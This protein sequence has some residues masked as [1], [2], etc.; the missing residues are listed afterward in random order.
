MSS[1][2]APT[3]PTPNE[4]ST[5]RRAGTLLGVTALAALVVLVD[6]RLDA[7]EAMKTA[8]EAKRMRV[9]SVDAVGGEGDPTSSPSTPTA[10]QTPSQ[11]RAT[12]TTTTT[13]TRRI[14]DDSIPPPNPHLAPV[15]RTLDALKMRR[16]APL[17]PQR[18]DASY[19]GDAYVAPFNATS[20][21]K[22]TTR[23]VNVG[24]WPV[25]EYTAVC[26]VRHVPTNSM[27]VS[28]EAGI[29]VAASPEAEQTLRTT[30]ALRTCA[31]DST[32]SQAAARFRLVAPRPDEDVLWL[33]GTTLVVDTYIASTHLD[34]VGSKV[35]QARQL[36]DF[37]SSNARTLTTT[38]TTTTKLLPDRLLFL[39]QSR[40]PSSKRP[41]SNPVVRL[42][43][44][45][46]TPEFMSPNTTFYRSDMDALPR[47]GGNVAPVVCLE[48]ALE[49]RNVFERKFATSRDVANWKKHAATHAKEVMDVSL[50]L[51]KC[52][53]R[54]ND[55][56]VLYRTEGQDLRRFLN[57][58]D[59]EDVFDD[60]G[61]CSWGYHN[62]TVGS[63]T[64]MAQQISLFWSFG[65]LVSPHS[66]QLFHT[67]FAHNLSAVLEV[68]PDV[69]EG[70][71][72]L[73]WSR[74]PSPYCVGLVCPAAYNVSFLHYDPSANRGKPP[75]TYRSS[76]W[77]HKDR[78]REALELLMEEQ[79]RRFAEVGCGLPPYLTRTRDACLDSVER[80]KHVVG[81]AAGAAE[82]AV[83]DGDA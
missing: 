9:W 59:L 55:V 18:R 51:S 24:G 74:L 14:T 73:L 52:P 64:P 69:G 56:F 42:A 12:T 46:L 25:C 76:I 21:L 5:W 58:K 11:T 65:L 20:A 45:A 31:L 40:I 71:P 28:G 72:D 23:L 63:A 33:R 68:R 41:L 8:E 36:V 79:R 70:S 67:T 66:A 29:D 54:A 6:A 4:T 48:H 62:V 77:I 15:A 3:P 38:T 10:P 27:L 57:Y 16:A 37:L 61:I 49:V 26:V 22:S 50:P 7:L 2:N 17:P 75:T 34:H 82:A 30:M 39:Q 80:E 19:S 1:S 44:L 32:I 43:A 78:F 47:S 81:A 60:V 13:T 35:V 83:A 53:P